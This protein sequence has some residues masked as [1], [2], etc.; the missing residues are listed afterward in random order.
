MFYEFLN[1]LCTLLP[2]VKEEKNGKQKFL[3]RNTGIG[4]GI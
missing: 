3:V 2:K 4:A 1:E